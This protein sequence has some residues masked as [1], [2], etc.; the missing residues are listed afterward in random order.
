MT[1]ES[2]L[3]RALHEAADQCRKSAAAAKE[4]R[5]RHHYLEAAIYYDDA[6][7]AAIRGAHAEADGRAVERGG[8]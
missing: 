4:A 3:V 8:L 6:A 2:D 7:V 5:A 1:D